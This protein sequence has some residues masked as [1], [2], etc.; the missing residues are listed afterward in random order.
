MGN[1]LDVMNYHL[2][3]L[4]YW[5]L[6]EIR[7]VETKKV[8]FAP[9]AVCSE[10]VGLYAEINQQKGITV[11]NELPTAMMVEAD[12][13]HVLLILRNLISNAVKF[14]NSGGLVRICGEVREGRFYLSVHDNGVGIAPEAQV[15]LFAAETTTSALGTN[16]ERGLGLGLRLCR[17]FVEKNEGRLTVASEVNKGS[18]F[19][20][21]L[22]VYN[23]AS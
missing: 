19:T 6:S 14:T 3:N 5:S 21:D 23:V 16:N 20:F 7:G 10:I 15:A 4:L 18:V 9:H 11:V 1:Q 8:V 22:H 2:D 13:N 12:K 17:E